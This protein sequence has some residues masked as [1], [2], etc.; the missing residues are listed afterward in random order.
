MGIDGQV[1][2]NI[3]DAFMVNSDNKVF[4]PEY[5]RGTSG[6][7]G[8]SGS[9]RVL[10]YGTQYLASKKGYSTREILNYYYKDSDW[11]SD[12]IKFVEP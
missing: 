8:T 6:Q 4:F 3:T 7:P 5:G 11:S 1:I 9:G 10:Q 12:G 2:D